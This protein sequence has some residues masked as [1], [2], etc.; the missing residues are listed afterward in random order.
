MNNFDMHFSD[1]DVEHL[2]MCL[3]V[4]CSFSL[5]ECH[6]ELL[7]LFDWVIWG[8]LF[9]VLVVVVIIV[10]LY[11][12]FIRFWKLSPRWSHHLQTYSFIMSG[13]FFCLFVS[14]AMQKV[15]RL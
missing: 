5:E 9:L 7:P 8:V 3:F 4:I 6:L 14:F 2:F 13:V 1:N 12:L 15:L 11:E 10:E